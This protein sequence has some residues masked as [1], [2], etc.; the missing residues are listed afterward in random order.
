[1]AGTQSK[2]KVGGEILQ[3]AILTSFMTGGILALTTAFLYFYLI[4]SAKAELNDQLDDYSKLVALLDRKNTKD[5]LWSLRAT[6]REATK[7]QTSK[8]LRASIEDE[9]Q[10]LQYTSLPPA[11]SKKIGNTIQEQQTITLKEAPLNDVLKFIARVK[12]QNP[13]IH[14][15]YINRARG[16][17]RRAIAPAPA[18]AGAAPPPP[19]TPEEERWVPKVDFFSFSTATTAPAGAKAAKETPA[20]EPVAEE[21]KS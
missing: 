2:T 4:P 18:P 15:G 19:P 17:E 7:N 14:V 21:P 16:R 20:P 6:V 10:G 1:M 12:Q 13:N 3:I 11:S 8:S 5:N 9:L